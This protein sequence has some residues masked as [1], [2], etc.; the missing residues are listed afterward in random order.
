MSQNTKTVIVM[1]FWDWVL[2]AWTADKLSK[3]LSGRERGDGS[4]RSSGLSYED[5]LIER[6]ELEDEREWEAYER[7]SEENERDFDSSWGEV[8]RIWDDD[9]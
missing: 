9:F 5:E 3:A 2:A 1:S 8:D 6:E 7:E 4:Y